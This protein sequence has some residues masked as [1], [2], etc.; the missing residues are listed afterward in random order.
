MEKEWDPKSWNRNMQEDFDET[1]E[2]D[3]LK[4]DEPS[5]LIKK[6]STPWLRGLTLR[7]LKKL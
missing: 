6:A 1:E 7:Y 4:F 2:V 3:P 5:L